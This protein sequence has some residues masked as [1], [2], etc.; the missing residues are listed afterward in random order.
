MNCKATTNNSDWT[1]APYAKN[2]YNPLI[3]SLKLQNWNVI[4]FYYDWRQNITSNEPSL[5]NLI[6]SN[7]IS[8]EKVDLVA[9]SMGGLIAR[10]Y[11]ETSQNNNK[12]SKLLMVGTPN[13]GSALAYPAFVNGE[14]WSN[15]LIEKI[16]ATLFIDHCGI[17]KSLQNLLSTY[18]YLRDNSTKQLKTVTSQK[19]QNNYLPTNFAAPFWGVKVGTLAGNGNSTLKIIDVIKDSKWPDGKP[20]GQ[21]NVN[22]GDDTVL[23]QSAQITGASSNDI[24][25]Q[26]HS[27]LVGSTDGINH[28][29]S[30]L[31][32]PGVSD[33]TYTEP[34]SALILIGYPGNFWVTDS[35]GVTT[36]SDNGMVALINPKDGDYQL[37][38]NPTSQTTNFIVSQFLANGQNEYEEY[39]FTGLVQE[40]K[41]VEFSSKN[42]REDILHDYKEYQKPIFPKFWLEFWKFWNNWSKLHK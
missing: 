36:Q 24:I 8:G 10:N 19:T 28:I 27:G 9:H 38:V 41:I 1:L 26:T 5:N 30:F 31:G 42:P 7:I 35:N 14:I 6:N 20:V 2:I 34:T 33:P 22:D 13:Q 17:P 12:A 37:Q 25:N 32:S 39:K 21:E 18:N 15:D 3:D 29:L 4:P 40:P 16:A 23:T 11:L